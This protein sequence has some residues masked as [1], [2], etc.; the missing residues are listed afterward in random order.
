[1]LDAPS[2]GA[3]CDDEDRRAA[4]EAQNDAFL[5][6]HDGLSDSAKLE[7]AMEFIEQRETAYGRVIKTHRHFGEDYAT[8]RCVLR[9]SWEDFLTAKFAAGVSR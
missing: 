5:E 2:F 7:L 3:F 8:V 4:A 6:W 1:M 9:L